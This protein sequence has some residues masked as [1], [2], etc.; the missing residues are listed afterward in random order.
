[1]STGA[2]QWSPPYPPAGAPITP[3]PPQPP[4]PP[5]SV[6]RRHL[7]MF[8]TLAA[9]ALVLVC[10]AGAVVAIAVGRHMFKN[11]PKRT[12]VS[13]GQPVR[14]G[15]FMFTADK[16]K[17][18][19]KQI[20]TPDDFQTPTGQFC[21]VGIKIT[22]VGKEPAIYAD[23]IQK[24]FSPNGSRYTADTPAGYYANP[25]P[26]I[27]M[28]EINPGNHISVQIV[29]DIPSGASI[30]KLELHENPYTRGAVVRMP[31]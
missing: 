27:F 2:A 13:M 22:N 12:T 31:H 4:A 1:M 6:F 16:M 24:A 18:G 20:G 25:D 15:N 9:C 19:V 28:N 5:N 11:D 8:V 21:I 10:L 29:Y 26:M 23:S 30:D 7:P 17:C 14:D 3:A